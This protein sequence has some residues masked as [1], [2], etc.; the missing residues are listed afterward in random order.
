MI[1][2]RI[3]TITPPLPLPRVG[4]SQR[5]RGI[6]RGEGREVE[7]EREREREIRKTKY[8]YNKDIKLQYNTLSLR[9]LV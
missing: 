6:K 8:V 7:L 3:T 5:G 1:W 4:G 9:F 2:R